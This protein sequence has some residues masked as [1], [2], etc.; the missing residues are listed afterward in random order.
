MR[1]LPIPIL[2]A[3]LSDIAAYTPPPLLTQAPPLTQ[4]L[5]LSEL[6]SMAQGAITGVFDL[7]HA[8]Q[9]KLLATAGG[10]SEASQNEISRYVADSLG[11]HP[12]SANWGLNL[13]V[14][15]INLI[16]TLFE[17]LVI[18]KKVL[19]VLIE[20]TYCIRI[21]V[22]SHLNCTLGDCSL[23][24]FGGTQWLQKSYHYN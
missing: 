4:T 15:I 21:C 6:Q 22:E 10:I 19:C 8:L 9:M 12:I 13:S 20:F 24:I 18:F 16:D 3:I 11:S 17:R 7:F 14:Q 23:L 5:P 2:L 1:E